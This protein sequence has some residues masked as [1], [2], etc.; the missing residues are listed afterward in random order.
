MLLGS[1]Y[2]TDALTPGE[3]Y[4]LPM[5]QA[6][7]RLAAMPV[8]SE[9]V[10]SISGSGGT[11]IRTRS[12][13]EEVVWHMLINDIEV[14]AFTAHLSAEGPQ[15]TRVVVSYEPGSH[16][17]PQSARLTSTALARDLAEIAM[18]EQ[19]RAQ[20]EGRPLDQGKML[21]EIGRH[22]AEHPE[23]VRESGRVIGDMFK[24]INSQAAGAAEA[25]ANH[26]PDPKKA[27][28][29]ATRPSTILP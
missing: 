2:A 8:P 7:A 9:L 10:Q 24:E 11:N 5:T 16:V 21:G 25:G 27:M 12:S 22:A 6:Q 1:L 4:G 28:E 29:A 19:V 15:Q 14:A 17:S 18:T 3:V 20:L 26:Q 13:A 23:Q